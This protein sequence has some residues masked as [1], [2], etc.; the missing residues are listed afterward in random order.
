MCWNSSWRSCP[1]ECCRKW[2]YCTN[3][4]KN[5]GESV[6]RKC[7]ISCRFSSKREAILHEIDKYVATQRELRQPAQ[8]Q[9][10]DNT[11]LDQIYEVDEILARVT[12]RK[13]CSGKEVSLFLF[14]VCRSSILRGNTF[15]ITTWSIPN[16]QKWLLLTTYLRLLQEGTRSPSMKSPY[17]FKRWD[18]ILDTTTPF[19]AT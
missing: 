17:P 15:M 9:I 12:R 13:E 19:A 18:G 10:N 5:A 11:S 6:L 3:W 4:K 2:I 7:V 1:Q 14:S 16:T 8:E